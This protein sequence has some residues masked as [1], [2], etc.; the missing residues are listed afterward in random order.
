VHK[1]DRL[2]KAKPLVS[3]G[4]QERPRRALVD[5]LHAFKILHGRNAGQLDFQ[6]AESFFCRIPGELQKI[7]RGVERKRQIRFDRDRFT[8]QEI[9][10]GCFSARV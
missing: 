8:S 1:I 2:R 9:G 10:N 4:D 6:A 7:F 3:V 5:R